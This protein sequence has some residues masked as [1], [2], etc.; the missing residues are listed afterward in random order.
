MKVILLKDLANYGKAGDIVVVSTGYAHNCL[1]PNRLA[2]LAT[3]VN[4]HQLQASNIVEQ[5]MV[6]ETIVTLQAFKV[7]IEA[8]NLEFVLKTKDH[9]IFG[10]ISH[11]HLLKELA[12]KHGIVINKHQL[13]HHGNLHKLGITKVPIKLN[14]QITAELTVII[15]AQEII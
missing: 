11:K 12:D 4:K 2:K 15:H 9:H 3:L 8:I 1:I 14:K 10:A 5:A 6:D 7:Q 13:H